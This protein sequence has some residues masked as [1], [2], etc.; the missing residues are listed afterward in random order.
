MDPLSPYSAAADSPCTPWSA[1]SSPNMANRFARTNV[2]LSE[3]V[4]ISTNSKVPPIEFMADRSSMTLSTFELR[5][6]KEF[7]PK[8]APRQVYLKADHSDSIVYG[9]LV[10][11]DPSK[12]TAYDSLQDE[13]RTTMR[14]EAN[15][16]FIGREDSSAIRTYVYV[17]NGNSKLG[18]W[19]YAN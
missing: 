2:I 9:R 13:T 17:W 6:Y 4:F 10:Y 8:Y 11:L 7:R 14:L 15:V 18:E 5:G 19:E 1:I 16:S 12:L 3:P